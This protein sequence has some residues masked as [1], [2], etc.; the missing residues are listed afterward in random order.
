[1]TDQTESTAPMTNNGREALEA[2]ERICISPDDKER[3]WSTT[4]YH[5]HM[6][7]WVEYVRADL[8]ATARQSG[9]DEGL[10]IGATHVGSHP[11]K[12]NRDLARSIRALKGN[13]K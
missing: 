13:A 4:D 10:E 2:P 11:W 1:M 3:Q 5:P 8:I 6:G 9:I 7:P 12:S